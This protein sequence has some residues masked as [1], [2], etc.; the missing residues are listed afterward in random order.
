MRM[1]GIVRLP[2]DAVTA[3]SKVS[4]TS[5]LLVADRQV[6]RPP[7]CFRHGF[8]ASRIDAPLT[9]LAAR[10]LRFLLPFPTIRL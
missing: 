9:P 6:R 7:V 5:S 8:P 3:L 2:G 1:G 10:T 4:Q